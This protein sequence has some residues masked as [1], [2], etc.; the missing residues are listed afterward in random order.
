MRQSIE[1]VSPNMSIRKILVDFEEYQNLKDIEK[2]YY[3][4][5]KG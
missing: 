2:K 5:L 3:Q 4:L 1:T